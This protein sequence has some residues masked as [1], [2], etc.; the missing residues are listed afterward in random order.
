MLIIV[1]MLITNGIIRSEEEPIKERT[2]MFLRFILHQNY[3]RCREIRSG[4]H[5]TCH[6]YDESDENA[7]GIKCFHQPCMDTSFNKT[8]LPM[9]TGFLGA[10][11]KSSYTCLCQEKKKPQLS[12]AEYQWSQWYSLTYDHWNENSR[13]DSRRGLYREIKDQLVTDAPVLAREYRWV[14]NILYLIRYILV[15]NQANNGVS[16]TH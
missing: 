1:Y 6:V 11:D 9:S 2:Q 3:T 15:I 16:G 13:Y 5:E 7:V 14:V 12:P 4:F 10:G 8:C